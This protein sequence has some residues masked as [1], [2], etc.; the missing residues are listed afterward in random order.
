M[1]ANSTSSLMQRM[2][3][4]LRTGLSFGGARDYYQVFGYKRILT[5]DD[6][7]GKYQR[8]DIAARVVD[9]PPDAVWA[10]PPSIVDNSAADD[11]W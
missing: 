8:Q 3:L 11:L 9:S 7:L 10:Y 2:M 4:A 5:S 1:S 6:L